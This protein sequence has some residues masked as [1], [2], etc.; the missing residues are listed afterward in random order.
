MRKMVILTLMLFAVV[1]MPAGAMAQNPPPSPTYPP[2]PP[3]EIDVGP[4]NP[5]PGDMVTVTG[6]NWCPGS[7]V[8]L[9]LDVIDDAH[10]LGTA[11]VD[12]NGQFTQGVTIPPGTSPGPHEILASGLAY[13]C[14]DSR[15]MSRTITVGGQGAQGGGEL[16]FTGSNISLGLLVLAALVIGGA[17]SLVAA[18]RRQT[19]SGE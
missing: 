14:V 1:G 11:T 5:D 4:T 3:P 13:N 17:V 9:Y 7:E 8:D 18:R 19:P 2:Q 12:K 10:Y 6:R 16:P 15:V